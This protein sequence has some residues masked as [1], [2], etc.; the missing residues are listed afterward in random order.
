MENFS[1]LA[2]GSLG[3]GNDAALREALD[4]QVRAFMRGQGTAKDALATATDQWN[5]MLANK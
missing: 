5:K 2:D 3:S 1:K 4:E